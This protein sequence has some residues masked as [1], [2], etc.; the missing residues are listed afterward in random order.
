MLCGSSVCFSDHCSRRWI[1]IIVEATTGASF[2]AVLPTPFGPY[3]GCRNQA[4][5][6]RAVSSHSETAREGQAFNISKTSNVYWKCYD[7]RCR[8]EFTGN[9]QCDSLI[10]ASRWAV[11]VASS[12]DPDRTGTSRGQ[13]RIWSDELVYFSYSVLEKTD[14]YSKQ[15]N[16]ILRAG[17]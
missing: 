5:L 17:Q 12:F 10:L 2:G 4:V 16:S 8:F 15:V 7:L 11:S 14:R 1:P 13:L 3:L 9:D 6:R